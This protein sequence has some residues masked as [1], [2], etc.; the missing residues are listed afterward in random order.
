MGVKCCAANSNLPPRRADPH[1]EGKNPVGETPPAVGTRQ[2][3]AVRGLVGK[4]TDRCDHTKEKV[5]G[6]WLPAALR[7][8]KLSTRGSSVRTEFFS[9]C[10][11]L[12]AFAR[13]LLL[14]LMPKLYHEIWAL[15]RPNPLESS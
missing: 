11:L 14:E 15:F 7:L 4:D 3:K 6:T 1:A 2:S 5:I 9:A 13:D 10:R 8:R 12:N